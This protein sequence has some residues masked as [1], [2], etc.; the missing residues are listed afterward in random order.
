MLLCMLLQAFAPAAAAAHA[1]QHLSAATTSVDEDHCP[2]HSKAERVRNPTAGKPAGNTCCSPDEC[3]CVVPALTSVEPMRLSRPPR[4]LAAH[5]AI[6]LRA[7]ADPA[8]AEHLR[9]PIS[10]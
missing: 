4:S 9:P 8:P 10:A 7:T 6:G 1:A 5:D 3:H 2:E